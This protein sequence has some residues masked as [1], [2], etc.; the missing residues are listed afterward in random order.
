MIRYATVASV[1]HGQARVTLKVGDIETQK[2]RWLHG[3][4]GETRTWSPPSEGEQVLLLC[5][6]GDIE[7]GI[8]LRGV[9][10]DAFPPAG[11]SKRELIKFGDGAVIA[12]DPESHKLE[13]VLPDGATVSVV[14]PGGVTIDADVR[15]TRDLQVDGRI[16]ADGDIVADAIS[17]KS[18]KH[19]GV[20]GGVAK[21]G[22]PE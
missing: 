8:A 1:D 5:P 20:Q 2:V 16:H 11:D 4:H 18:H 15:I 10:Y 21:T 3:A 14:A 17:L 19:G 6:E 12:Y 7:G 22:A 13:A 9:S